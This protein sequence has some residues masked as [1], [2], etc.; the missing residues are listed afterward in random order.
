LRAKSR[1][2]SQIRRV[3]VSVAVEVVRTVERSG[4]V[5]GVGLVL[6]VGLGV[7]DAYIEEIKLWSANVA[8][9]ASALIAA[10]GRLV[11][12]NSDL[13][14]RAIISASLGCLNVPGEGCT[15]G[16]LLVAGV[17]G[18]VIGLGRAFEAD[19]TAE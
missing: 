6:W 14:L 17:E 5:L 4:V 15:T 19:D 2:E 8:M 18:A 3:V 1:R 9:K 12:L 13:F 16:A 10:D 11:W 7:V